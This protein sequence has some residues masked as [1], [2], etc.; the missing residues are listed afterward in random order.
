MSAKDILSSKKKLSDKDLEEILAA[1]DFSDISDSEEKNPE[2]I[3]ADYDSDDSIADRDYVPD[4]LDEDSYAEELQTIW[5]RGQKR[6]QGIISEGSTAKKEKLANDAIPSTSHSVSSC[7]G[8][9]P[10]NEENQEESI[11][12]NNFFGKDGYKWS[13]TPPI[14]EKGKT[15]ARNVV[16]IRPGRVGPAKALSEPLDA[17]LLIFNDDVLSDILIYTNQRIVV[18]QEKYKTQNA[19]TSLT[20]IS[21]LKALFGLLILAAALK[22]NHLSAELL[23]DDSF[24]GSRYRATMS[25][26]TFL[27]LQNALRFDDQSTR[28]E[29]RAASNFAPIS[30]LWDK[31]IHNC[32]ENYKPSAYLCIDEQLV[33][34][35][36]RCPFRMYIPNKP[37]KYG[38]KIVMVCDVATKYVLNASPYLGKSTKTNGAPLANYYVELL[39]KPV[40]G[41]KRNITMDNWFTNIP[42]SN[43]LTEAPFK[44]TVVGT[45]RK[46]KPQIP[47]QLLDIK[48]RPCKTTMAVFTKNSTLISYKPKENKN[49]LLLST[50]HTSNCLNSET[51]KPEI[52]HVYN[53]TKGAVDTFD[54]MSQNVSCNRKTRRWPLCIFYNMMNIAA[55][56]SYVIYNHNLTAMKKKP[57]SRLKNMLTLHEQLTM[58]WQETRRSIP[59]LPR[60]LKECISN[61]MGEKAPTITKVEQKGKRSYCSICPSAKKRMTTTYCHVCPR[62]LCGEHQIKI[63]Y[64]CVQNVNK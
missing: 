17:F 10:L 32:T 18:L 53:S 47:P 31:F 21:E 25:R 9:T 24:S 14:S 6:I 29:R 45:L 61:V 50:M 16:Y 8:R 13:D 37:N 56:N 35:R 22:S 39:T 30:D 7:S 34:F 4:P 46:N 52:I 62:A 11:L 60:N 15:P 57:A 3:D 44:L 5:R 49:V 43:K 51:A 64:D 40:W 55:V 19:S 38:I 41:T 36:G 1:S 33:G 27:F 58:P 42:L 63:C 28:V 23:F 59:T 26:T 2:E 12:P 20:S 48:S 54:Q